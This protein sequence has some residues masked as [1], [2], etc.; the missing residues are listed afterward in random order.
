MVYKATEAKSKIKTWSELKKHINKR[1]LPPS[2]KK[3][4]YLKVNSLKQENLKLE[5]YIREL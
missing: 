5:E 2:Y 4:L 3:E 1:S